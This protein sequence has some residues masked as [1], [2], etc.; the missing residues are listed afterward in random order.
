MI[1]KT[2]CRY[3]FVREFGV[4]NR[5]ENF[6]IA[7]REAL[8]DYYMEYA[9]ATGEPFVLDVIGVCC[10]WTEYTEEEL[11]AECGNPGDSPED[12]LAGIACSQFATIVE[13][14][15]GKPDTYLI[16]AGWL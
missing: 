14:G 10:D 15:R 7:A 3:D 6:T 5:D 8:Y 1:Y 11:V 13:H 12:V 4:M 9:D 2:L 16:H